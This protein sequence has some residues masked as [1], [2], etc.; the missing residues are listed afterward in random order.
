VDAGRSL[1]WHTIL[2]RL[3]A[4]P[5]AYAIITIASAGTLGL[6]AIVI[7]LASDWADASSSRTAGGWVILLGAM[8]LLGLRPAVSALHR[9]TVI[10][11][12]TRR[13]ATLRGAAVAAVAAARPLVLVGA[14]ATLADFVAAGT[15]VVVAEAF[16]PRAIVAR[17]VLVSSF[18]VAWWLTRAVLGVSTALAVLDRNGAV[19]ALVDG[20][21]SLAA[22]RMEALR[23]RWCLFVAV[24]PSALA[25]TFGTGA[26]A[27]VGLLPTIP[28]VVTLDGII[29]ALWLERERGSVDVERL[30]AVFD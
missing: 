10:V 19:A 4:R 29:E 13:E 28:I 24:L 7:R 17:L 3:R 12:V 2:G 18:F 15:I 20:A 21:R 27:L 30:A 5:G 9:A 6:L 11:L 26:W 14:A 1:G 22:R 16:G 23:A 8:V 25:I